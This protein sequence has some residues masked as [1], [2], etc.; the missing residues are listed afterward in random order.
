MKNYIL[1]FFSFQL[2]STSVSAQTDVERQLIA[3][4]YNIDKINELKKELRDKELI[5]QNR[6]VDYL[7]SNTKKRRIKTENQSSIIYDIVN[8]QPVY[9]TSYNI[10][11]AK[12]TNTKELHPGGTTGFDL[13]GEN[14][15]MGLWEIDYPL[16]EHVE[17]LDHQT[18]PQTRI[19]YPDLVSTV[20]LNGRI[21]DHST[22]V[23]GTIIGKGINPG[24]KGMAPK[25][26]ISAHDA[27]R[28]TEEAA[29][30][31]AN[32]LLI[33]NHSYGVP[34][35]NQSGTQQVNSANIGAY[36]SQAQDWD[37]VVFNAPYYLAVMSA[38]NE[39]GMLS[40]YSDGLANGYDKLTGDKT[41]KNTLVVASAVPIMSS[42]KLNNF[43][44]SQFSSEG[45]TDDFRIKPDITGDGN[46]LFSSTSGSINEYNTFQGTSMASPS[47]SGSLLLLQE[48]YNQLNANYMKAATLKGLACHNAKDDNAKPGPDPVFGWGFY[49][50]EASA[51]TIQQASSGLAVIKELSLNDN[52]SYTYQFSTSGSGP[53]SAT[54]CWTD[55]AGT[56]Q[57]S[58]LNDPTPHLVNDLD[59][60]LE[61]S[62]NTMYFP[63][64]LDNSDATAAAIKGDNV[65]DNIENIDVD[66]GAAG[67]YTLTV[68]HKGTLVNGNQSFSL[69]L[70]GTNLTLNTDNLMFSKVTFWP[71]PVDSKLNIN[72][73]KIVGSTSLSLCNVH[74]KIIYKKD[75]TKRQNS[76]NTSKFSSGIYFLTLKNNNQTLIKKIII[77]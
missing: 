71:N 43:L 54:I 38:G 59:L 51:L 45:P 35:F 40:G 52:D 50:A 33:S 23:S 2:L 24:A 44:S 11:A 53:I 72:L 56:V 48:Y 77:K 21:D 22:H 34:I 49:D 14:M 63:W 41:A 25:A 61:H 18:N 16:R 37:R 65:V 13:E 30:A 47:V 46:L 17:L 58:S 1:I 28:D 32:G 39:G 57:S 9:K 66:S 29:T 64:K 3:K 62:S 75:T 55:P 36:T 7:K 69:I 5:R 4:S 68:N 12:A 67:T 6:I 26:S 76:I 60:R 15:I 70:T 8:G 73:S 74:G 19:T 27:V 31:A 42:G 20:F 10:D